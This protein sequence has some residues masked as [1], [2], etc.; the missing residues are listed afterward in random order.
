MH[1]DRGLP[2]G[3]T[4]QPTGWRG[5]CQRG[6]SGCTLHTHNIP[7]TGGVKVWMAHF[8]HANTRCHSSCAC[9]RKYLCLLNCSLK[10]LCLLTD[11]C[12]RAPNGQLFITAASVRIQPFRSPVLSNITSCPG[13]QT[14]SADKAIIDDSQY[15]FKNISVER[16]RTTFISDIIPELFRT[17]KAETSNKT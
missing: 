8:I 6:T 15:N 3:S 13:S 14:L 2:R 5:L 11:S 17:C 1:M 12:L 16:T 10:Y 7:T 9:S 4:K